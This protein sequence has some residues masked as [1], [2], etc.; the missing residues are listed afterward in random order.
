MGPGSGPYY[1][2]PQPSPC[3]TGPNRNPGGGGPS[4]LALY[5]STRDCGNAA[6][7]NA[8]IVQQPLA[9]V[10]L[11]RNYADYAGSFI[12]AHAAPGSAPFF[13]YMAFSHTHVPL[14]FDPKFA[15]SSAR[16]TLFADTTMELDDTVKRIWDAVVESG[17]ANNTLILATSDK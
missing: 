8:Q 12:R 10:E 17:Q 3:P 7:C 5:N 9:E 11:D 14:F 16:N 6:S 15:N 2:L 13:M 1:N 4:A